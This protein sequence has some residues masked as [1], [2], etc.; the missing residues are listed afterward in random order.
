VKAGDLVEFKQIVAGQ[1]DDPPY[2]LDGQWRIGLLLRY[3]PESWLG[4]PV[5]Y[6]GKIFEIRIE[7]MRLMVE[8]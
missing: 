3:P 8:L 2:S 6:R 1:D 4:C 5:L 7:N